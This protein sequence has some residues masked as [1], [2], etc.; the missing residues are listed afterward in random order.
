MGFYRTKGSSGYSEEICLVNII[1]VLDSFSLNVFNGF[2]MNVKKERK[3]AYATC[4]VS[5]SLV[6]F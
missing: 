4:V 3:C 5:F 6:V 2:T 1:N